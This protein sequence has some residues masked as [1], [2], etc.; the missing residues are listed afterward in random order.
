MHNWLQNFAYRIGIS[1]WIFL[2]V[3]L[4]AIGIALVTISIQAIKAAIANPIR[5]LRSE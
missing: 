1:W 2:A 5:A 3:G 4:L